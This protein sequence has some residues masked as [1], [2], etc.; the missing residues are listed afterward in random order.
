MSSVFITRKMFVDW[1]Q[2]QLPL[3]GLPEKCTT[4]CHAVHFSEVDPINLV[5]LNISV[6][7]G[8]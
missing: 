5:L 2:H 1:L 4:S 8:I 3:T 7:C 6:Y